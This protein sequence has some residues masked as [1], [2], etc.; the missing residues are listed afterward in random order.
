MVIC[1]YIFQHTHNSRMPPASVRPDDGEQL[2]GDRR[3]EDAQHDRRGDAPEDD[4]G[5]DLGRNARRRETDDDGVVTRQHEVDHGDVEQRQQILQQPVHRS[6]PC[7]RR[8]RASRSRSRVRSPAESAR[9][10]GYVALAPADGQPCGPYGSA[11]STRRET[12]AWRTGS[13]GGPSCG[14]TSCARRRGCRGSGT[15]PS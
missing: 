11:S 15:R 12:S 14:R 3:E 4:L 2:H 5:A 10:Q 1:R 6:P 13:C 8:H 9:R 7:R